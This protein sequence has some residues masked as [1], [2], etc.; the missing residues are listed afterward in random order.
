M[1]KQ[2][3][4]IAIE[5]GIK[6]RAERALT[7][8]HHNFKK[9][10]TLFGL[11]RI[12]TPLDEQGERMPAERKIVQLNVIDEL[13]RVEKALVELFDVTAAKTATNCSAAAD[14]V[15]D[16][17]TLLTNVPV[18]YLM[19]LEKQL[20]NLTTF[21]Q[22]L[23]CLDPAESWSW[24]DNRSCYVTEAVE[25]IRTK[26]VPKPIVLYP[27]TTEHPAQTQMVTE[28]VQ[29]GTWSVHKM[30]GALSI[31]KVRAMSERCAKLTDAVKKAREKANSTDAVEPK[32]GA[33]VLGYI[34]GD[35]LT[36]RAAE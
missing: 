3:Q 14:I 36:A 31:D 32:L 17:E 28:D 20:V 30:C 16:G 24:D 13:D 35:V 26:K 19:F 9:P 34:F 18:T 21:C 27:A 7:N 22:N 29:V 15:V 2:H 25:Q 12:Y 23:P 4:I 6:S 1:T 8:A 33:T 5:K 11:T 10:D